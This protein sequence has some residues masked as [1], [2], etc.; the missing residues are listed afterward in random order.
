M[1]FRRRPTAQ[2]AGTHRVHGR[3]IRP[4]FPEGMQAI[5]FGMGCFWAGERR[6]WDLPGVWT[7]A[8]GFTPTHTEVVRVV[9]DPTEVAVDD[10]LEVFFAGHDPT[11]AQGSLYRS[12]I[13]TDDQATAA[14]AAA[15]I[16]REATRRG[17]PLTTTVVNGAFTYAGEDQQQ[18]LA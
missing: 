5:T 4:P 11:V 18:Y 3:P 1:R 10:L 8:A 7:T 9:F 13:G 6:F 17:R 12:V 14:R 16:T 2:A 15:A